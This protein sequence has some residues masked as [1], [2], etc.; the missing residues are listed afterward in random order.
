MKIS[1]FVRKIPAAIAACVS[2]VIFVPAYAQMSFMGLGGYTTSAVGV[3]DDGS[4]VVGSYQQ[5]GDFSSTYRWTRSGGF[6]FFPTPSDAWYSQAAGISGDG[7]TFVGTI[8]YRYTPGHLRS[9][10]FRWN[11]ETGMVRLG[12]APGGTYGGATHGV[13]HD[14]S[15]VTVLG[16]GVPQRAFLWSE[17]SGFQ[18]VDQLREARDVSADGKVVAGFHYRI[19][20]G[21]D[22]IR[23]TQE[24]GVQYLGV[25]PGRISS[26]AL[27]I[28]ADGSTIVGTSY[29]NLTSD[30]Q[31]FRWTEETGLMGL[32]FVQGKHSSVARVVSGDGSIILGDEFGGYGDAFIWTE[33]SGMRGLLDVLLNVYG[34]GDQLQG[35]SQLTVGGISA[36]GR[37]IV[38]QGLYEGLG[39]GAWI[40]DRG[41]NPPPIPPPSLPGI[42]EPSTYGLLGAL[43]LAGLAFARLQRHRVVA[44]TSNQCT[45]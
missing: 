4:V 20:A 5:P 38:G 22:A 34:L 10:T 13:S 40:L 41:L 23:W 9:E 14:G 25:L 32:G 21:T 18:G 11:E 2:S 8:N 42:P 1:R 6:E 43:A 16:D 24:T 17:S 36:D 15:V 26:L 29:S 12:V 33:E 31:A 44:A 45:S 37:F 3:S 35:W 39:G 30:G 19:P 28:S 27:G 7:K